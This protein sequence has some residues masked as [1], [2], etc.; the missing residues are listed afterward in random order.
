MFLGMRKMTVYLDDEEIDRLRRVAASTGKSQSELV[1]EGVRHITGIHTARQ[2]RS[3]RIAA[4]P[5]DAAPGWQAD[6]LYDKL[7]PVQ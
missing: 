3:L 2:F 7:F 5:G 4:G 6:A 1:R